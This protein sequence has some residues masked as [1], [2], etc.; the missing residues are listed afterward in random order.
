LT[1][2]KHSF[3]EN[4]SIIECSQN[5]ED[6]G[7]SEKDLNAKHAPAITVEDAENSENEN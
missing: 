7:K 5:D 3:G 4:Q 6:K 2:H 1:G